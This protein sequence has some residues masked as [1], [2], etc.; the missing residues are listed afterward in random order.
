MSCI[1][2]LIHCGDTAVK[3]HCIAVFAEVAA[4][5]AEQAQQEAGFQRWRRRATLTARR[6]AVQ[7]EGAAMIDFE[8]AWAARE[9]ARQRDVTDAAA[10]IDTLKGQL[11]KVCACIDHARHDA[12][13]FHACEMY[14]SRPQSTPP[15]VRLSSCT[16]R[17]TV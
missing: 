10:R 15:A 1:T 14:E 5:A 13:C 2:Q 4:A 9:E 16:P 3:R 7:Q 12:G 11:L 17:R 6:S 8:A